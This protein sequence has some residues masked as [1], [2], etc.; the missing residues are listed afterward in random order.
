MSWHKRPL[1]PLPDVVKAATDLYERSSDELGEYVAERLFVHDGCTTRAGDLFKNYVA[2]ADDRG[3]KTSDRM[4]ATAFGRSMG[5]RFRKTSDRHGTTYHGI[6]LPA[7]D[8]GGRPH[9]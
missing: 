8:E 9:D 7:P 1:K 2:W 3:M 5:K 6:G 4:T